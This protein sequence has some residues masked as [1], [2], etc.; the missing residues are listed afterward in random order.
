MVD[1]NNYNTLSRK[2]GQHQE[3]YMQD[4]YEGIATIQSFHH[5]SPIHMAV[6]IIST[7][8]TG[9][10]SSLEDP[11]LLSHYIE[12]ASTFIVQE[13]DH[14]ASW[15]HSVLGNALLVGRNS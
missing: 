15:R 13:A 4:K 7:T 9:L 3:E 12:H 2:N 1:D 10:Y 11:L 14:S 6:N 8:E 5:D